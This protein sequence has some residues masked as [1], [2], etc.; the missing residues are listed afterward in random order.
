MRI[1]NVECIYNVELHTCMYTRNTP[2]VWRA[3]TS[4]I[5]TTKL[6]TMRSAMVNWTLIKYVAACCRA[7]QCVAVYCSVKWATMG[8]AM[9]N[10]TLNEYAA[11]YC[12]ELQ[13]VAECCRVLQSVAECCSV[14]QCVAVCCR[15][16]QCFAVCCSVLQCV[17]VCCSVLQCEICNQEE[18]YSKV[19]IDKSHTKSTL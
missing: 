1:N 9:V 13:C 6:A 14:L 16:L 10:W 2:S 3:C 19:N 7:L 12:R 4:M 17:A 15:V 5:F 11:V 8:T 18:Q